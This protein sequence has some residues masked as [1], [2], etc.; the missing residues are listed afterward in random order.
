[1]RTC[2]P[3][4]RLLALLDGAAG[5]ER[6]A[7]EAHVEGCVDCQGA[8]ERLC[9]PA[10]TP[11]A[12]ARG[13]SFLS[14]LKER[15]PVAGDGPTWRPPGP[16]LPREV[17]V[18]RVDGYEVL[19]ELGRGGMAVVYKA[20]HLRLGRLVALK[21]LPV[22]AHAGPE[23]AARFRR[24][25]EALARLQHPNV[26]QVHE[27]G[28]QGDRPWLALELVEGGS[29]AQRLAGRP[30]PPTEA[31]RLAELIA[32]AVQAAHEAGVV[33]RDLKPANVLLTPAGDPK[34]TDFGLA[35]GPGDADQTGTGAVLGTPQYMAPEQ[36]AGHSH[37]AGPAAD[38]W[39]LGVVLYELL[40]GRPPFQGQSALDTL[41][42][43]E[44]DDPLP[45]GRYRP[46]VPRDLETVCLKC[47]EKAPHR[48]Y[49]S[50]AALADD[51]RRFQAGMPVSAR[52]LSPAGRLAR[53]ARRHPAV[54]ALSAAVA[55]VALAGAAAVAWQWRA[56]VAA[57]GQAEATARQEADARALAEE[58]ARREA[59]ARALAEGRRREAVR[60]LVGLSAE[61]HLDLC[62]R[63][64]VPLGL[65]GLADDLRQALADAPDETADLRH[66]I[67]LNLSA[68]RPRLH[69]L[70]EAVDLGTQITNGGLTPDGETAYALF[71][72]GTVRLWAPDGAPLGP[73]LRLAGPVRAVAVS[74]DRR[75]AA[76]ACGSEAVVWDVASG[77]P[78]GGPLRHAG[79]VVA[80]AFSRDGRLVA[81][82]G[83]DRTARLWR[84]D[85]GEAVGSPLEHTG[86]VF[87][88][89]FSPDGSRLVTGG[90]RSVRLW[91]V[92]TGRPVGEPLPLGGP[93]R[94][95]LFSPDGSAF[96][97]AVGAVNP[98]SGAVRVFAAD[99][100]Q[101]R[102]KAAQF[103]AP[104]TALAFSP[105]GRLL[106][107][108]SAD[109]TARLLDVA[110]GAALGGPLRHAG[111]VT[112]AAFDPD[113]SCFATAATAAARGP[114]PGG[115]ARLW[116][117]PS[118]RP[119]GAP[120]AHPD[121]PL[122]LAFT[123]GGHALRTAAADGRLRLWALAP[124]RPGGGPLPAGEPQTAAAFTS[125]GQALLTE[126]VMG[127]VRR[128]DAL[129]GEARGK[130]PT[131]A[132]L[133]FAGAALG[134][135]G[136]ALLP[137]NGGGARL[138][139][140]AAG[141]AA[142]PPLTFADR[143]GARPSAL[144]LGPDG[145]TALL[146]AP[147]GAVQAWD[148]EAGES[149]GALTPPGPHLFA[150]A[151][152][153]DRR[154]FLAG[155]RDGT[156]QRHDAATGAALGPPL[157]HTRPVV[158]V[159]FSG[160]GL[161]ART[162][163][164]GGAPHLWDL[165]AGREAPV[166]LPLRGGERVVDFSPDGRL[167]VTAAD[168]GGVRLWDRVTG[169]PVG[170]PLGEDTAP[171]VPP[172]APVSGDPGP[173]L[174]S[175]DGRALAFRRDGRVRLWRVPAADGEAP[176]RLT[177]RLEVLTGLARGD[178]GARPLSAAEWEE[179]RRLAGP[180]R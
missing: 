28:E 30:L 10:E 70:E 147:D 40:A 14:R 26:V 170:P 105:D 161:L 180:D 111:A 53:W 66:A 136:R 79:G 177:P 115:E 113:G 165:A 44:R 33:H 97:A 86:P 23:A 84:A 52:P 128:W 60:L 92:D 131:P 122:G 127:V 171:P 141:R 7:L 103:R 178:G 62:A 22:G 87:C 104:V 20:R 38:V 35:R 82:G 6:D 154:S 102:G 172:L 91:A 133:R 2:P 36:A 69:T 146:A 65:F 135:H 3:A 139:D 88:L 134:P 83:L 43:V 99:S 179:R 64:E 143:P 42:R 37:R 163:T 17:A 57:R 39:A 158:A 155:R 63:G 54:A 81:T 152:A 34:V 25:A 159:A 5:P 24:E 160:D 162:K 74:P 31:A 123:R 157:R 174:F 94:L 41:R 45:P 16:A 167:A 169:L 51:L 27:A 150:L 12:A 120:L 121:R 49:P 126:G 149:R 95:V 106:V 132:G 166:G 8:L 118:G 164:E 58:T 110:T 137:L 48:R 168:D 176:E 21:V 56:A 50:A 1:M 59:D 19:G 144:A 18:P 71:A 9:G 77:R 55:A 78:I 156:A 148:A 100:G 114:G 15:P 112:A 96:A 109:G 145:R 124:G 32:R 85:G 75:R 67:R 72:D 76:A 130:T 140:L 129:T 46:G 151:F 107:A 98:G 68:W 138:W 153:P 47:L 93:V 101:A 11:R 116:E 108:G 119:L 117:A 175:P 73:P 13:L 29:L 125:D 142:G 4:D 89:D 173:W 80:V 90:G 61:R